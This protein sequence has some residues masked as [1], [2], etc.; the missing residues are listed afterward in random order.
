MH[1]ERAGR[2]SA[3]ESMSGLKYKPESAVVAAIGLLATFPMP[4][5]LRQLVS[6]DLAARPANRNR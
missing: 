1:R 2:S 6:F 5:N 4:I 3:K